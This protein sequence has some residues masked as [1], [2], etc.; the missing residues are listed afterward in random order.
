MQPCSM[1]FHRAS[2]GEVVAMVEVEEGEGVGTR[3]SWLAR[4]SNHPQDSANFISRRRY[5]ARLFFY[6]FQYVR[7]L[8]PVDQPTFLIFKRFNLFS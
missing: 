2:E 4:P 8:T 3:E 6:M 7:Q 5:C 1:A